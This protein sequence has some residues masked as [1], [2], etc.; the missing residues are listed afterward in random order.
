MSTAEV[1]QQFQ[2][3]R[4]GL[5]TLKEKNTGARQAM[6][7]GDQAI[8]NE[9]NLINEK[10]SQVKALVAR[11]NEIDSA[12]K[13]KEDEVKN[14]QKEL[15]ETKAEFT[16]TRGEKETL[17]NSIKEK[18]DEI[19]RIN[20]LMAANL[21]ESRAKDANIERLQDEIMAQRNNL[22]QVNGDL[23]EILAEATQL[24]ADLSSASGEVDQL[25][26]YNNTLI[27]NINE[28]LKKVN[29]DLQDILNTPPPS[30]SEMSRIHQE[31]MTKA[32]A[33]PDDGLGDGLGDMFAEKHENTLAEDAIH[34]EREE[35][36]RAASEDIDMSET[37]LFDQSEQE[38]Q[39]LEMQPES[40]DLGGPT[41]VSENSVET[42]APAISAEETLVEQQP[43][44]RVRGNFKTMMFPTEIKEY[45]D[46]DTP[47]DRKQELYEIA[48]RRMREIAG[49]ADVVADSPPVV[50]RRVPPP[51]PSTPESSISSFPTRKKSVYLPGSKN[52]FMN[53][54]TAEEQDAYNK[55]TDEDEKNALMAKGLA[56]L[57]SKQRKGG[58]RTR[59]KRG[60][61]HHMSHGGKKRRTKKHGGYIAVKPRSSRKSKSS[62]SSSS[63]KKTRKSKK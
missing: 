9:I 48:N 3:T 8:R 16:T 62:S 6:E 15:E 28:L 55:S 20:A 24:N 2:I 27:T 32:A 51:P 4:D 35:R 61:G 19:A 60:R 36:R 1:K 46:P 23:Q 17:E 34:A 40:V 44:I 26:D 10:I 13:F 38:P 47:Q 50:S 43:E 57:V 39:Q 41:T 5:R 52:E 21:D 25:N 12:L 63:S 22:E 58:R 30:A 56:E 42:D 33:A 11:S 7:S 53:G 31:R 54:L 45:D 18:E 49:N 59:R 29:V 37:N 14:L